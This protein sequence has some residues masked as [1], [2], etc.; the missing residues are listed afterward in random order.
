MHDQPPIPCTS[1]EADAYAERVAICVHDGGLDE[2]RAR[3]VALD[4]LFFARDGG[5][6]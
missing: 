6:F 2:D 4:D 5:R 3:A 1:D